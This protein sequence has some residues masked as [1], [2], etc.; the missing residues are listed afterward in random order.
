M[1]NNVLRES[2][3]VKLRGFLRFTGAV[4]FFCFC[5]EFFR[6]G[7]E[8]LGVLIPII[9]FFEASLELLSQVVSGLSSST[10]IRDAFDDRF[11]IFQ[12]GEHE[13]VDA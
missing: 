2:L 1:F 10:Y 13:W 12:R 6:L 7:E 5:Y 4:R 11:K 3:H 9:R 8:V